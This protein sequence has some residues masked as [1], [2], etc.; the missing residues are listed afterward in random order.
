MCKSI[1][2]AEFAKKQDPPKVYE[3]ITKT[4]ESIL[5]KRQNFFLWEGGKKANCSN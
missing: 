2:E 4:V 3:I 1:L 5:W